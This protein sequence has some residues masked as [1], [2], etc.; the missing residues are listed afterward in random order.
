MQE[1][2]NNHVLA[3]SINPSFSHR[4]SEIEQTINAFDYSM[5]ILAD[6]LSSGDVSRYVKGDIVKPVFRKFN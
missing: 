5:K 4:E 1:M 6:A 2:A 3:Q